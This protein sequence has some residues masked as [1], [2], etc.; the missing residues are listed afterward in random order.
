MNCSKGLCFSYGETLL[1]W[2][3]L[4]KRYK[5]SPGHTA[6]ADVERTSRYLFM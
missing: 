1:R 3:V 2:A 5:K 6:G 4:V